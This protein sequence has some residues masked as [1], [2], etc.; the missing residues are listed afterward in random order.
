VSAFFVREGR[1]WETMRRIRRAFTT[2]RIRYAIVGDMAMVLHGFNRCTD[3]IEI[4]ITADSHECASRAAGEPP[5][6]YY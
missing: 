5:M 2:Q 1:V 3:T 4:V 6:V